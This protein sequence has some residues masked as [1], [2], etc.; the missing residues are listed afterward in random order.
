MHKPIQFE[1]H[2]SRYRHWKLETARDRARLT[3]KV[4]EAGGLRPGN[5]QEAIHVLHPWGV[6]VSSGVES[7]PGSP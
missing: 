1:T 7:E 3:M 5:V 4:D 2:P 6:D